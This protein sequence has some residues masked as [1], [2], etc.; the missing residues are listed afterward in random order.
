MGVN[1]DSCL[2][3]VTVK[4]LC[5][6]FWVRYLVNRA[7][8]VEFL[9]HCCDCCFGCFTHVVRPVIDGL[10]L[11]LQGRSMGY[12]HLCDPSL[13]LLS[14]DRRWADKSPLDMLILLIEECRWMIE[15]I[16]RRQG[17]EYT[18]QLRGNISSN[19]ELTTNGAMIC[20]PSSIGHLT[21]PIS[22]SS[23]RL[24]IRGDTLVE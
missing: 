24:S 8:L 20:I 11:P 1:I 7:Y 9:F 19:A 18:T 12:I 23:H 13:F 21:T 6:T 3:F 17:I 4:L 22:Y 15:F 2:C 16:Y 10:G 5:L 14:G